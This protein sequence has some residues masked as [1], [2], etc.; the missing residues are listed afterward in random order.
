MVLK[1]INDVEL[2]GAQE[3]AKLLGVNKNKI[4]EIWK[5]NEM[6][7][8]CIGDTKKTTREAVAEYLLEK[9]NM[10]LT[11]EANS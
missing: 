6:T 5:R 10:D 4:Y 2:I 1:K 9:Q 3:A 7:W 8:W 11:L